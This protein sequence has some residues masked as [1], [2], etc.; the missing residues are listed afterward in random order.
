MSVQGSR[1]S[2]YCVL[3]QNSKRPKVI[4]FKTTLWKPPESSKTL[5]VFE[6][7]A[8]FCF[9]RT[10]LSCAE[11]I[12]RVIKKKHQFSETDL[13]RAAFQCFYGRMRSF[14]TNSKPSSAVYSFHCTYA[15]KWVCQIIF[16]TSFGSWSSHGWCLETR[17]IISFLKLLRPSCFL[18]WLHIQVAH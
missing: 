16:P 6:S 14:F 18:V 9:Y 8:G 1:L 4:L 2:T 5:R 15:E 7:R 13:R 10:C 17:I 12:R 11:L 3:W